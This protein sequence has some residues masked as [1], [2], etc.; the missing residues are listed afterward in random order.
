[1]PKPNLIIKILEWRE[2]EEV[3][4]GGT[5]GGLA[6]FVT[7]LGSTTTCGRIYTVTTI[8]QSFGLHC[9]S[10]SVDVEAVLLVLPRER[11]LQCVARRQPTITVMCSSEA[12]NSHSQCSTPI[13]LLVTFIAISIVSVAPVCS[14]EAANS[15]SQCSTPIHLLVTFIAISIVSVA[16]VCSSVAANYHSQCSTPIHLLVTFIAISI[17]SVAPVCSSEAAN[18]HSQCSTPIHLL[19]TFIAISM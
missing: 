15:H 8:L 12:A 3:K 4:D 5:P 9:L 11:W 10:I 17:V 14:S 6:L 19:V 2:T 13:H 1:M 16:P 7:P 18:S